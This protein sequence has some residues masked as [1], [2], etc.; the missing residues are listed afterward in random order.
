MAY[1]E[2]DQVGG[3]VAFDPSEN[4]YRVY[5]RGNRMRPKFTSRIA[6]LSYLC[7]L[8]SGVRIAELDDPVSATPRERAVRSDRTSLS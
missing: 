5:W 1:N 6:A 4:V 8:R 3:R 2:Y 7:G